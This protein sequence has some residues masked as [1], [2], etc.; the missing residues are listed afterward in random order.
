M[1]KEHT[2]CDKT[3]KKNPNTQDSHTVRL[4]VGSNECE[5]TSFLHR[6]VILVTQPYSL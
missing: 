3:C 2:R 1:P 6:E 5:L 4:K